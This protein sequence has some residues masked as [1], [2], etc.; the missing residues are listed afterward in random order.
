MRLEL[1]VARLEAANQPPDQG[2]PW[3]GRV[4]TLGEYFDALEA[5]RHGAAARLLY[6]ALAPSQDHGAEGAERG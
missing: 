1:R 6:L 5:W 2:P 3:D 4:E